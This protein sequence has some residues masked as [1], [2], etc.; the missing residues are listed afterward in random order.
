MYLEEEDD[1]DAGLHRLIRQ[2][3]ELAVAARAEAE[4]HKELRLRLA[5]GSPEKA[6]AQT[7]LH[8]VIADA[9]AQRQHALAMRDHARRALAR[10]RAFRQA[11]EQRGR[12][13]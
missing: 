6:G 9:R 2:V 8:T 13:S 12:W 1:D 4:L 11:R 7:P 5:P 10:A 3:R